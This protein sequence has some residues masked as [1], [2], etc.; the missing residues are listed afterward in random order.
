VVSPATTKVVYLSETTVAQE[1]GVAEAAGRLRQ[2]LSEAEIAV[3]DASP[4]A[5]LNV[6]RAFGNE[7]VA[8]TSEMIL[9]EWGIFPF[10][11]KPTIHVSLVRQLRTEE[12]DELDPE[13]W[14]VHCELLDEPTEA[15]R[16][17][18]GSHFWSDPFASGSSHRAEGLRD[19]FA[20]VAAS[21]GFVEAL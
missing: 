7:L 4:T 9:F 19:F 20:E 11:G 5:V 10:S 21:P 2:S 1:F 13:L 17:L 16:E 3:S 14:Q 8:C 15:F 12:P 6:F 18:G